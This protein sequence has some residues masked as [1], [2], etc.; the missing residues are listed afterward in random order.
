MH[1]YAHIDIYTY[2]PMYYY[3]KIIHSREILRWRG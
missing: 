1:M 2:T 3:I